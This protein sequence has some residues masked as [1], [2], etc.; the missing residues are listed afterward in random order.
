MAVSQSAQLV[1]VREALIPVR[2]RKLGKMPWTGR[3]QVMVREALIPVRGRKLGL[4]SRQ[5]DPRMNV[6]EALIPVRGRK[7]MLRIKKS[8]W[9]SL[10]ERL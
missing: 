4:L 5:R 7:P 10:S 8:S 3:H 1:G 2:G 9:L 6:R